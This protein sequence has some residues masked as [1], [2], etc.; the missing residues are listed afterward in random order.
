MDSVNAVR[1]AWRDHPLE[2]G[3]CVPPGWSA[4]RFRW[5]HRLLDPLVELGECIRGTG[6]P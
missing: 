6:F 5:P 3:S 1:S 4:R 2:P